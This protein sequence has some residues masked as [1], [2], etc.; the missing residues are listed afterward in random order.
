MWSTAG[1]DVNFPIEFIVSGEF[2]IPD[3]GVA[4]VRDMG[5]TP[6]TGLI[7]IPLAV[8]STSTTLTIP[9][10]ENTVGVGSTFEVRYVTVRFAVGNKTYYRN[11]S[12]RVVPFIPLTTTPE[13]VR[14]E[15]GLDSTELPDKDIDVLA[16]Y[17]QLRVEYGQTIE[18]ALTEGTEKTLAVNKAVG[19]QAALELINSLVFRAAVKIKAEDSAIE[20]MSDFDV[21]EIRIRL[22]QRLSKLLGII[23]GEAEEGTSIFVLSSPTDAIT[24]E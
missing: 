16:A 2:V 22:G 6:I 24:G 18:D 17:I 13:D 11:F 8:D 5:G 1:E 15:L 10:V 21:N 20:R 3:S 9:G 23:Q 4:T 7:D 12:Y 19:V 14:R